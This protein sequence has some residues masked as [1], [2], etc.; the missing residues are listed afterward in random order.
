MNNCRVLLKNLDSQLAYYPIEELLGRNT[1][2]SIIEC[3]SMSGK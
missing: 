2:V 1:F 3:Y